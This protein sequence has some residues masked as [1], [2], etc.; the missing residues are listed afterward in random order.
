MSLDKEEKKLENVSKD[1]VEQ[2]EHVEP[3]DYVK[4]QS[5]Q[6]QQH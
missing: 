5:V 1:S 2:I 4:D 6:P 3:L